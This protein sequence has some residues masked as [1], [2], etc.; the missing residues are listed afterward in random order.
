MNYAL[1]DAIVSTGWLNERLKD[2]A[3]RIV[4]ASYFVPGGI[5]PAKKQYA[6]GHLPGAV[7]FDINDIADPTGKKDHTFPT[8]EIF[9]AKVGA[10]GIGNQ[11][12]VIAYDH[13]GGACAASRVWWMMR[14]FGHTK[15]S[16]LD[17]GLK[18]WTNEGRPL[19]TDVPQV[20]P[21]TFK[22]EKTSSIVRSRADMLA[23]IEK[24]AW[25][26]LDVRGAG[27]FMG[28][29]PEPRPGLRSGH[30]PGA[31]NLPFATLYDPATQTFKG[32]TAIMQAFKDAGVDL[33][34]DIV[35]SCGSGV[36]ACAVAL[37]AYL[38]GKDN[39]Q[40]YDGS[41]LEWGSDPTLPLETGPAKK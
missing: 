5:E 27:R 1:T 32:P 2:P 6:E 35:T 10:L 18:K 14:H 4:D 19:T 29:D 34:K 36:T 26:M 40:I 33:T 23:N 41:W 22:A 24:R 21:E 30:I 9:A 11:H 37:G 8:A 15:V 39:V 16:V 38:L 25:Q 28:T 17:G 3:I 12:H 7:F 31:L 20:K 13:W